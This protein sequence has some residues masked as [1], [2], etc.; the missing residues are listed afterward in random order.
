MIRLLRDDDAETYAEL[1]REALLD[2]PLAFASSPDDDLAS[3]PESAR[4]QLRR[5][6]ESVILGAFRKGLVGSVGLY[7]DR[8]LK[9]SHKVHLWGMYVSPAYRRQGIASELLETALRHAGSM[10][11]VHW[12]HLSVSSAAREALR[13][14]E[15]AGFQRWGTE[16]ESLRHEGRAVS[17][18]HMAIRLD[19][20]A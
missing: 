5:A 7:R 18:H 8:H 1:R 20:T 10:P 2:S 17:E 14:Y 12:V 4:A 19:T 13:L 6:P 15:S 3:T 9:S 16:P 11:G